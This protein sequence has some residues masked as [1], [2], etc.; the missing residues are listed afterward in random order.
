MD[1]FEKQQHYEA[2]KAM[3]ELD[4][5]LHF[6]TVK[7]DEEEWVW[8]TGFKGTDKNMKCRD[9]Q[10]E[11]SIPFYIPD[12]EKVAECR[13]GFHLCRKLINVFDYY[14]IGRGNRFFEVRALVRKADA[15]KEVRRYMSDKIAAK[16]IEFIRELDVNEVLTAELSRYKY[17]ENP[18][19]KLSEW[20][21][22]AK[23]TAMFASVSDG[24]RMV[25]VN[26]LETLGYS[27][28]F[29]THIMNLGGYNTAVSVGAQKD[30]SMD[31]KA[32][33]IYDTIQR[34]YMERD[35]RRSRSEGRYT[36]YSSSIDKRMDF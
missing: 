29:A 12:D 13:N 14:S 11:M 20:S 23:K 18:E 2:K 25:C 24:L 27:R 16:S 17:E 28:P 9:F 3:A 8:I 19:F 35:R 34:E 22:E 33:F 5:Q 4:T 1:W 26:Y 31:M 30:L 21:D 10:Y 36:S 15:E 7:K 32:M 6:G